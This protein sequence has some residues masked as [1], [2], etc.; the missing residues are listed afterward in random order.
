M[1]NRMDFSKLEKGFYPVREDD[2]DW[3]VMYFDGKD[4]YDTTYGQYDSC[5]TKSFITEIGKKIV[6]PDN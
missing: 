1:E 5:D 6:L 4:F 2:D 3:E